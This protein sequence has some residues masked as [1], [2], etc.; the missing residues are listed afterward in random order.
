MNKVRSVPNS[1]RDVESVIFNE[2]LIPKLTNLLGST[3]FQTEQKNPIL[4][5]I[6]VNQNG[7]YSLVDN[8]FNDSIEVIDASAGLKE[9]IR[10]GLGW[11]PDSWPTFYGSSYFWLNGREFEETF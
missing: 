9:G 2:I 7:K 6:L 11:L 1:G 8:V 3:I 10:T 4:S 5:P